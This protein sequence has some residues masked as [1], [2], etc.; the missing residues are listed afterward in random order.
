MPKARSRPQHLFLFVI[1]ATLLL[2]AAGGLRFVWLLHR[3]IH[4]DDGFE[5]PALSPI[6]TTD[7][8]VPGAFSIQNEI[9]HSGR[10]AAQITVH[11]ND[12]FEA[13]SDDGPASE[14]DEL[15]EAPRYWS[16]SGKTY[17]Y[18]F[19]LYL[20]KD[21]PIV[22]TRLVISQWKQLCEFGECRPDNPVLAIRYVNGVL[23]VTRKDNNGQTVL[24]KSQ[25]EIRGQ[26]LSFRFV[27]RFSQSDD[28]SIDGS[29]NG[30]SIV[31]YR[32]VT[33]YRTAR[34]YPAHGFFFFKMGL[35][36]DQMQQPMTIYIDDYRKD[37]CANP[38][39]E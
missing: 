31:H 21:F 27:T 12:R 11:S 25:G 35:Y 22:S 3:T 38:A 33:A 37:Q 19:S 20:P 1:V 36:R 26:W 15:M 28:G 30:L 24:Y 13:G 2:I 23:F 4:T 9:V 29:L 17:A 8:M 39:C 16:Q 14:R 5:S 32:G 6:W 34:G 10:S 7:R 18:S